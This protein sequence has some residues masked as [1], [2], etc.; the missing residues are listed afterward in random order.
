MT[1]TPDDAARS[2]SV[3]GQASGVR[4]YRTVVSSPRAAAMCLAVS[5]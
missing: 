2:G 3:Y 5:Q 1:A 4:S